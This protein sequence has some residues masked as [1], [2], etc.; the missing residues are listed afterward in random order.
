MKKP[1]LDRKKICKNGKNLA[2]QND[3]YARQRKKPEIAA[4]WGRQ[5]NGNS[6]KESSHV[7]GNSSRRR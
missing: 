7:V 4:V 3:I 5:F 2:A 1:R 6:D